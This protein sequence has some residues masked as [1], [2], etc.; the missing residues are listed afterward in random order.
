MSSTTEQIKD[1]LPIEDVV[2]MYVKL[3]RSGSNF[4]AKCP[5]HNEKTPS[6]FVSPDRGSYYCFGC[7]AKGDIFTFVEEFEGL[8]FRGALKSLA[9]RAGVKLER[10]DPKK[11]TE[12]ERVLEALEEATKFFENNLK[13]NRKVL[14]YLENRGL[15]DET[16]TRFRLGYAPDSW[17]SLRD[18]LLKAGFSDGILEKSGLIIPKDRGDGYDRFRGRIMFPISDP[19]GRVVG[20][21]G[22]ISSEKEGDEKAG[23]KYINS[24]ETEVFHKSNIL[25]GYDHAKKYIRQYDFSIMVE[26]Q[27]DLIMSHQVGYRNAVASSGTSLTADHFEKLLRMSPNLVLALDADNAGESSV[28]RSAALALSLGMDVKVAALPSGKD[29]ADVIKE[30]PES[31]KKS[32]KGAV[33]VI[34]YVLR[35]ILEKE[36]DNRKKAKLISK[37]VLPFIKVID[38]KMDQSFFV[39][40]ISEEIGVSE[41][42]VYDEL[43]KISADKVA[44][45]K[46]RKVDSRTIN[47][48]DDH[49]ERR[50]LGIVLWQRSL[51]KPSLDIAQAE[52]VLKEVVKEKPEASV[53]NREELIFEAETLFGTLDDAQKALDELLLNWRKDEV[54]KEMAGIIEA[55]KSAEAEGRDS[56]AS[57]LLQQ[58][59]ELAKKLVGLES[60]K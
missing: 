3:E 5:F 55:L 4:K 54:K 49:L 51:P 60:R 27:M 44:G 6:F 22:R 7:G 9:D 21:S 58:Y 12:K 59:Q 32:V 46:D 26:G 38:N 30:D 13:G 8:D 53:N 34:D 17:S 36:S 14:D 2:G 40:R 52:E 1:R 10:V 45:S 57:F 19:S 42:A 20:F 23:G 48:R 28:K 37:E 41:E 43:K 39:K 29:P 56:D 25:Y 50:I 47:A 24:P 15:E 31:W 18:Y 16:L 35:A 11:A 33:H